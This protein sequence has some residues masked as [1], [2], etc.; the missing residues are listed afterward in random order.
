MATL[1]EDQPRLG[2]GCE[3]T[4]SRFGG[5]VSIGDG[6][7]ILNSDIGDYSYTDRC[8]DI[9]NCRVGKFANIAS[10]VRI[11]PTDH[12]LD[13]ASLHHFLYRS[14]DYWDGAKQDEAFFAHRA[15]RRVSIGH[16]TWIGHGAIIRPEV[17]VQD[18]AVVGAGA[19]V[20][21]DVP[22][23]AVVIGVPA[24]VMRYRQ[25]PEIAGRLR[26]LAW[27]D[28]PHEKLGDAL[29]DFRHLTAAEFLEKHEAG[30]VS[31]TALEQK[32]ELSR[33]S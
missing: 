7:R 28:W 27:W 33:S 21:R 16:D 12:P 13:R 4:N 2:E 18:G 15:S 1:S 26:A 5:F 24:R 22:A 10:H 29:T 8:A 19:V 25:P 6:S 17:T 32:T 23:Y 30:N 31:V 11:G 14:D 3:I 9:A 20:T